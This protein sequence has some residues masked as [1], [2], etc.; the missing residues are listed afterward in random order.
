MK[1]PIV[2]IMVLA[3]LLAMP[4]MAVKD[5]K[6]LG[7]K[8]QITTDPKYDRN[9]S[10]FRARDGT[11]WLFYTRGRDNRGIRDFQSYNPDLDSYDIYYRTARSIEQLDE[12]N[13]NIIRLIY[14]DNAQRDVAALQASDGRIWL[15][16][17][18]G[19]GPGAERSV[20]Y[21]EYDGT[22]SGP[23]A[24]PNTGYA[25]HIDAL[26]YNGR[27]WVFFDIGYVLEVTNYDGSTWSTP[28]TIHTDATV[29]KA[30]VENGAFYTVWTTSAGSGI[31]LST[32]ADGITWASTI[33]PIAS[34]SGLTDWD[35]VLIK[36][37]NAFRL[38]WAPSD[39]GQFIATSTSTNPMNPSSWSTPV[40]LTTANDWWDFWP[41]PYK[42]D[43]SIYL[44]YTSERN[45]DGTGR[46]DGNIWMSKLD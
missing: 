41:R 13:D 18:T 36:D 22:W 32:S 16:A 42:K 44:F 23:T 29:A 28:T 21:Y 15:F 12:A 5:E 24:I 27:I 8:I 20:Y 39:S 43:N 19:L 9:P 7:K 30:I 40:K 37:K 45:S 17:S 4:V 26:E 10:F 38:F 34:W 35:P 25:A 2:G 11:Y 1:K 31:Y 6:H 14:P 46:T 33:S 3:I